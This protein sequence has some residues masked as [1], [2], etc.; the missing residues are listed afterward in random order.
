MWDKDPLQAW[1]LNFLKV[2]N[3]DFHDSIDPAKEV[4]NL[5]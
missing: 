2:G 3:T 4:V 1:P 5:V